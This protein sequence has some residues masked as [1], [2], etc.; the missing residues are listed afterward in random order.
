M[1]LISFFSADY[2]DYK[3][4]RISEVNVDSLGFSDKGEFV[5]LTGNSNLLGDFALLF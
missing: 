3:Q 4:I 5:E 1:A 2:D